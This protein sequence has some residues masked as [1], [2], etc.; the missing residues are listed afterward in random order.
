MYFQFLLTTI[1]KCQFILLFKLKYFYKIFGIQLEIFHKN[2]CLYTYNL[3]FRNIYIL[4][5]GKH[6]HYFGDN[7]YGRLSP[8]SSIRFLRMFL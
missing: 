8:S 6:R 1:Y 5:V 2:D 4:R 3:L 7:F